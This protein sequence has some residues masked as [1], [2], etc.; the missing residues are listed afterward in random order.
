M[1]V[2]ESWV[3]IL[4]MSVEQGNDEQDNHDSN[5][6]DQDERQNLLFL[7]LPIPIV[8]NFR[9]LRQSLTFLS[10]TWDLGLVRR[11]DRRV[12]PQAGRHA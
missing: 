1:Q 12:P 5:N 2:N 4:E 10:C 6:A 3:G 11:S 8:R 9:L 7:P